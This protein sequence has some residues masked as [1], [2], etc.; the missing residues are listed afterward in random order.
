MSRFVV[1]AHNHPD[2]HFDF[3][4]E[5][6]GELLTW[7]LPAW[8]PELSAVQPEVSLS[9]TPLPPHRLAYL[10]YEGPV[11]GNRGA[12]KRVDAGKFEWVA[13]LPGFREISLH[14]QWGAYR[15]QLE[16]QDQDDLL[17]FC[18]LLSFPAPGTPADRQEE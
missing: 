8:P 12:V 3:M 11:S 9:A 14:S 10:E 17:T 13:R 16:Q 4:L 5:A 7:R 15:V 2:P 18:L 6:D 1:L